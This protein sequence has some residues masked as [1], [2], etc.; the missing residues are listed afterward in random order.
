MRW[1]RY[2]AE[3]ES[4]KR[5]AR[6]HRLQTVSA[7]HERLWGPQRF[8]AAREAIF[9]RYTRET[10]AL[11][12]RRITDR[13]LPISDQ[14]ASLMTEIDA[15]LDT[16]EYVL[17][18]AESEEFT[19][20]QQRD[21]WGRADLLAERDEY[22]ALRQYVHCGRWVSLS[23]RLLNDRL[24]FRWP[25]VGVHGVIAAYGPI[26]GL[27]TAGEMS[28]MVRRS[29]LGEAAGSLYRVDMPPL[30]LDPG[31]RHD[32]QLA[33]ETD[34]PLSR[35][36]LNF[37]R[38]AATV[39]VE[40]FTVADPAVFAALDDWALHSARTPEQSLYVRR[41]VALAEPSGFDAW[42]YEGAHPAGYRSPHVP[43]PDA[44]C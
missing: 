26:L 16:A 33:L 15:W 36:M 35:R 40:I 4:F 21:V 28:A 14:D 8:A 31:M 32:G 12:E 3:R 10:A 2:S 37:D 25:D 18:A 20:Q 38:S 22:A 24:S 13:H 41:M 1:R 23:V 5:L 29:A 34:D 17:T 11:I 6:Q 27:L 19:P 43:E 44:A 42:I 30:L 9:H 39:A 7:L